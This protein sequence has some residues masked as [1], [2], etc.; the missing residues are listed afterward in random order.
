MILGDVRKDLGVLG[1]TAGLNAWD[2]Q[3]DDP[4]DLPAMVVGGIKSMVRLN[5]KVSLVQIGVTMYVNAADPE[6]ASRKLDQL[7]SVGTEDGLSFI[8]ILDSHAADEAASWRSIKFLSAGPYQKYAMPG[9]GSALGVEV[10]VE[11]TA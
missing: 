11:L 7:L 3:P 10:T 5:Q 2:Y 1:R 9:D 4:Q 6:D 8:D